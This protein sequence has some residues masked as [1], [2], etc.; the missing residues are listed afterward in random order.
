MANDIVLNPSHYERGFQM[1]Y[2][3]NPRVMTL[4]KLN[5]LDFDFDF[6]NFELWD[7]TIEEF[8]MQLEAIESSLFTLKSIEAF[9]KI[10]KQV[11]R[12]LF[13]L[14]KVVSCKINFE[15]QSNFFGDSTD[16]CLR[17]TDFENERVHSSIPVTIK[18]GSF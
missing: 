4:K 14:I 8:N 16:I 3:V 2:L 9:Q 6:A 12:C 5:V 18:T 11:V 10:F 15:T 1:L 17:D 13:K 7:I